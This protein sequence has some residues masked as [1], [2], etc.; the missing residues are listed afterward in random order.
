MV[1]YRN[2][3]KFTDSIG[4][5]SA[6]PNPYAHQQDQV[7]IRNRDLWSPY[8]KTQFS[9]PRLGL[10][11]KFLHC[12]TQMQMVPI[13]HLEQPSS[14]EDQEGTVALVTKIVVCKYKVLLLFKK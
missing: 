3:E 9:K 8:Q 4:V 10:Q 6:P 1:S 5:K 2:T 7:L 11:C 12:P 14:R 13:P